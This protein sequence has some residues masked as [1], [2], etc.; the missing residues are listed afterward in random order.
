M[1]PLIKVSNLSK[2]YYDKKK[3][4]PILKNINFEIMKGEFVSIIGP[5][6]CGKTTLL[7][8]IAGLEKQTSGGVLFNYKQIQSSPNCGKIGFVFQSH[9]LLSWRSIYK[10]LTLPFEL[11]KK[12]ITKEVKERIIGLL[13]EVEL[14][15]EK[16]SLPHQLS[17]GEQQ[18]VNLIRAMVLDPPIL[19]MD[20]PFKE[21]D[22]ID[23]VM[24]NSLILEN[25]KQKNDTVVF[26][27]HSFS[28]AIFLSDRIIILDGRPPDHVTEIKKIED[29][30]L[31]HPRIR[32]NVNFIKKIEC[33]RKELI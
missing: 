26:I 9:A 3:A 22:E 13:Q 12:P 7:K 8:I 10:N 2:E 29:I 17:G 23:R 18:R 25:H 32:R 4:I 5:N 14:E 6:G 31:P 21:I 33:I 30:D 16:D 24:L 27:T 15:N 20:E 28:E 1:L 19:F 11:L